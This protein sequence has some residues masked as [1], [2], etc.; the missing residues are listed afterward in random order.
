MTKYSIRPFAEY[1]LTRDPIESEK[2]KKWNCK[3]SSLRIAVEHAFGRLKGCFPYLREVPG[4]DML[5][6]YRTIEALFILHNIL[7]ELNDD[8]S[9]IEDYNGIDEHMGFEE[10]LGGEISRDLSA[11]DLY[12]TGLL[13]CK[14][15]LDLI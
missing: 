2:R 7:E 9:D 1:D 13:H 3:L 8:P 15:L 10:Q 5:Q 12:R 14:Q 6:D 11:Q 4:Y